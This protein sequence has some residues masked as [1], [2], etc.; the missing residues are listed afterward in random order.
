MSWYLLYLW[1]VVTFKTFKTSGKQKGATTSKKRGKHYY[2]YSHIS[3]RNHKKCERTYAALDL[4]AE[5]KISERISDTIRNGNLQIEIRR[6]WNKCSIRRVPVRHLTIF[7]HFWFTV[8]KI[9]IRLI[10][11]KTLRCW[12]AED[13][14][15]HDGKL[16]SLRNPHRPQV[17]EASGIEELSL[18]F[19][20]IGILLGICHLKYRARCV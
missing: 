8:I 14:G 10:S 20:W 15:Q 3:Y 13:A 17:G 5:Y 18:T 1:H 7:L 6:N 2:L 9:M 19:R 12:D 16:R 4:G 11:L